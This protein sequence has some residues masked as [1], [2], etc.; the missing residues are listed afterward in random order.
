[1]KRISTL[2]LVSIFRTACLVAI[3][4]LSIV[5]SSCA[6]QLYEGVRPSNEIS[7]ILRSGQV[8]IQEV[9]GVEIYGSGFMAE[10]TART[11]LIKILPGRHTVTAEG[12]GFR[13]KGSHFLS[14]IYG[15]TGRATL[16]WD[17]KAGKTYLVNGRHGGP[18]GWR[19]WITETILD[20]SPSGMASMTL[21]IPTTVVVAGN[22]PP[23][24]ITGD[25]SIS[26][27]FVTPVNVYSKKTVLYRG[28]S[29]CQY[30]FCREMGLLTIGDGSVAIEG[31]Y[32]KQETLKISKDNIQNVKLGEFLS[33]AEA[34]P[35]NLIEAIFLYYVESGE[36][37]VIVLTSTPSDTELDSY[38]YSALLQITKTT[39]P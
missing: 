2:S 11:G 24:H 19:I 7:T 14:Q 16:N 1:M 34:E 30:P 20:T 26:L 18:T 39:A 10:I 6:V 9:D 38:I 8:K 23:A 33:P 22:A 15:T 17:A 32:D 4:L 28:A 35:P 25:K 21:P 12:P 37:K 3:A 29:F 5:L 13:Y 27:P 31:E 36:N